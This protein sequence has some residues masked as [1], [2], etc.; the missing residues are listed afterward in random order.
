MRQALPLVMLAVGLAIAAPAQAFAPPGP[1]PVRYTAELRWNA[2]SQTLTGSE[3]IAFVNRG[4]QKLSSVWLRV[5]PNGYGSCDHRLARVGVSRG[6]HAGR[7]SVG[8]TVLRVRLARPVAPGKRGALRVGV[9]VKVPRSPNRFGQ[10]AGIVYLGN[11]LPLLAVAGPGGPALEPYTDLGDPFYSLSAAWSVR[12]DVPARLTAATTGALHGERALAHGMKRLRIA[13]AHARD[14][15]IVIGDFAVQTTR[16]ATGVTLRRYSRR[17]S[18]ASAA[19]ATLGVARAAVE[20]YTNWFGPPGVSEIDILPGPSALGSFGSGM[21]FPGLVLS[22]DSAQFAAHEIAHQWWYSLIGNDQWRSPWLD[23]AFAE[24]SSRRLPAEVVGP[25]ELSCDDSDPVASYG[26]SGPLTASM[27]H[28]DSVG[29]DEYYRSIYMGGAC[30]LRSLENEI[31][32][33]AMTGFLRAYAGAHRFGVVQT[34]DFV[35]A[36]RAAAPAGFD[37]DA[38]LRRTRIVVP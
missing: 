14:F 4:P 11:A 35:S 29:G 16:T 17:N 37:L 36:L 1:K 22:P 26:G 32:A 19:G 7:W 18:D 13:A 10:D 38:F 25:D 27:S 9:H 30:A 8:C 21:E 15:A 23:E 6:G 3:R 24:F 20:A 34:S 28:W 31:G 12:L 5:W 33:E 2:G